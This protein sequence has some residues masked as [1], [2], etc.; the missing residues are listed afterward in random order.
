MATTNRLHT[1][2]D[3]ELVELC[4]T[5][6]LYEAYLTKHTISLMIIQTGRDDCG[7]PKW[8]TPPESHDVKPPENTIAVVVDL[9]SDQGTIIIFSKE[10]IPFYDRVGTDKEKG[11]LIIVPWNREWWYF[12]VGVTRIAYIQTPG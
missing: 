11:N 3:G 6:V 7:F 4:K 10:A 8:T 9:R 2:T 12:P 5:A 1:A